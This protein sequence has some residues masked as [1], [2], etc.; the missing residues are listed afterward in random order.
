MNLCRRSKLSLCQLLDLIDRDRLTLLLDKY[1]INPRPRAFPDF[2]VTEVIHE[3]VLMASEQQLGE[4]LQ[5]IAGTRGSIRSY[6]SPR[7]RFD[8]RWKDLLLCLELDGYR[9]GEDE[10]GRGTGSFVPIE[11]EIEG[12]QPVEDDLAAELR[13]SGLSEADEIARVVDNSADA[14]RRGDSNGCLGSARV[15]LETLATSIARSRQASHPESFDSER[16]GQVI[17]YLRTSGFITEKEE[18]GLAGVYGFI[19]PGAHIPIGFTE[20]ELARLGRS[21]ALSFCY[22]L[23]KRFNGEPT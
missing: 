23:V 18:R 9:L 8:E 22:F 1:G 17:S 14:F 11:P 10:F 3:P 7:Y 12:V 21:M 16:W 19:S 5:E 13:R 6:I 20:R 15:A 4:I 2:S